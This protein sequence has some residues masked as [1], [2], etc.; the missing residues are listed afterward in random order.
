MLAKSKLAPHRGRRHRRVDTYSAV[1]HAALMSVDVSSLVLATPKKKLP[2]GTRAV[3]L[4]RKLALWVAGTSGGYLG[5]LVALHQLGIKG[6]S[7][8][9]MGDAFGLL[10]A[11]F[12]GL[13]L[14]GVG[15]A[16]WFQQKE[17]RLQRRELRLQRKDMKDNTKAQKAQHDAMVAAGRV[18]HLSEVLRALTQIRESASTQPALGYNTVAHEGESTTRTMGDHLSRAQAAI[19]SEIA[20][21]LPDDSSSKSLVLTAYRAWRVVFV[22]P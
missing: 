12:A 13:S 22:K 6:E 1:R 2:P 15:V 16:L 20:Q 7:L 10:N 21:S 18:A 9:K 11:V 5:L 4:F 8:S 14:A 17:I 19:I 3:R